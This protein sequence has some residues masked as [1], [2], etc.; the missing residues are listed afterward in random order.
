MCWP[1]FFKSFQREDFRRWNFLP[2]QSLTSGWMEQNLVYQTTRPSVKVDPQRPQHHLHHP[3]PNHHLTQRVRPD[4]ALHTRY[5]QDLTVSKMEEG[6]MWFLISCSMT[7]LSRKNNFRHSC[8]SSSNSC[9]SAVNLSHNAS[10]SNHSH[11]T[12]SHTHHQSPIQRCNYK[13]ISRWVSDTW[14][15]GIKTLFWILNIWASPLKLSPEF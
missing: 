8:S 15:L 3:P 10:Q 1:Q 6:K 14:N 9:Q 7:N 12:K 13:D 2:V 5:H 11:H 4:S